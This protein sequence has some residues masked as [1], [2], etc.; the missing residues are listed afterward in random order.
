VIW[1]WTTCA[2]TLGAAIGLFGGFWVG[3]NSMQPGIRE[4]LRDSASD[5]TFLL[6]VLR[7]E[8]ANWMIRKDPDRYVTIYKSR[9]MRLFSASA[10]RIALNSEQSLLRSRKNTPFLGTSI[11]YKHEITCFMR[12]L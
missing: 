9:R 4:L 5:R 1:V 8:L 10:G 11:Y 7:R 12:M 3:V 2:A 6:S